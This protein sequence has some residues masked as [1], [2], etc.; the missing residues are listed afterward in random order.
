MKTPK[1]TQYTRPKIAISTS[2]NISGIRYRIFNHI[3]GSGHFGCQDIRRT[4]RSISQAS[5]FMWKSTS[6]GGFDLDRC[7]IVS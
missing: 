4:D 1:K 3:G 2:F 7:Q 5:G 6:R